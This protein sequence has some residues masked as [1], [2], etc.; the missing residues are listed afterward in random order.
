MTTTQ[1]LVLTVLVVILVATLVAAVIPPLRGWGVLFVL[2]VIGLLAVFVLI[3][4]VPWYFWALVIGAF[5]LV[6]AIERGVKR[7]TGGDHPVKV[8][9]VDYA[10]AEARGRAEPAGF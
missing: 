1:T 9:V 3:F 7:L 4:F 10:D 6:A 5:L 8:E 2:G